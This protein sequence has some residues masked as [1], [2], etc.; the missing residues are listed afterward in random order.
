MISLL[1]SNLFFLFMSGKRM[2]Q[3]W[4]SWETYKRL[5]AV[6]GKLQRQDG[7]IRNFDEVIGELIA[8]W[9]ESSKVLK[10]VEL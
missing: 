1:S 4:V 9:K 7:K 2:T 3:V 8:F 5:L 6:R 10:E